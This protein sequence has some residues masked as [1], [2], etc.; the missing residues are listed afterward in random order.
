MTTC[1]NTNPVENMASII[2]GIRT[3]ISSDRVPIQGKHVEASEKGRIFI[4]YLGRLTLLV[5]VFLT[6]QPPRFDRNEKHFVMYFDRF[7]L[8]VIRLLLGRA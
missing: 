2:K 3:K 6:S 8:V 1:A 5:L 4:C 7:Y